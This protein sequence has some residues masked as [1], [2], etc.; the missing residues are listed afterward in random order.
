MS[1]SKK[2]KQYREILRQEVSQGIG[3]NAEGAKQPLR[4]MGKLTLDRSLMAG[5]K[6]GEFRRRKS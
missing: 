5:Y 1:G 2:Q 4:D 3:H 6:V